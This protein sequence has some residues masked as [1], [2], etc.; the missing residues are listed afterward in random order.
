MS[1]KSNQIERIEDLWLC[2]EKNRPSGL[3][4]FESCF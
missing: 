4:K 3:L 2:G 1:A